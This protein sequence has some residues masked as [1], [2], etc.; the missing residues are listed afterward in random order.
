[1]RLRICS[2]ICNLIPN[3][4]HLRVMNLH[5]LCHHLNIRDAAAATQEESTMTLHDHTQS[6]L[7]CYTGASCAPLLYYFNQNHGK[8]KWQQ[9]RNLLLRALADIIPACVSSNW[10]RD[11]K[12]FTIYLYFS[13]CSL[14]I[15]MLTTYSCRLGRISRS[16]VSPLRRIRTYCN[17]LL[18]TS[19]AVLACDAHGVIML[20]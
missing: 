9:S 20:S 6:H 5:S 17:F 8:I 11:I 16:N 14:C 15:D 7:Q 10:S 12:D 4:L 2:Q 1:M 18:S 13:S 3:Y 19:L